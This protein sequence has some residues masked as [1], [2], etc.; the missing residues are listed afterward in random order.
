MIKRIIDILAS[1]LAIVILIPL[2]LGI[3]ILIRL[4][5]RGSVLFVQR[6]IGV[7]DREF[8]MY[9][10]RTM[11]TGAPEVA[12]DQLKDSQQYITKVGYFLRKYSIDELPQLFNIFF[13]HMSL[14]GPRPALYNQYDLRSM[15]VKLGISGIP[16]GLTGWAQINGRDEITLDKKVALDHYYLQ[17]QTVGMDFQILYRTVFSV[18]EGNGINVKT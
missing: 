18:Y 6:R 13:G 17:N 1:L 15:R 7:D 8:L 9:K 14:V 16:P 10:F 3:A 5:S 2:L 12:T 11:V 4:D